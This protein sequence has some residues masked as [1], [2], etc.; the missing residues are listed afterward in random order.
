MEDPV[1]N[2]EQEKLIKDS[3]H[4]SASDSTFNLDIECRQFSVGWQFDSRAFEH[5]SLLGCPFWSYHSFMLVQR[6]YPVSYHFKKNYRTCIAFYFHLMR[7]IPF[8]CRFRLGNNG[9]N[10]CLRNWIHFACCSVLSENR[11]EE[12]SYNNIC[13][14]IYSSCVHSHIRYC[15]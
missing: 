7:Y 11:R 5:W 3:V 8:R 14:C 6:P 10:S 1:K 2:S 15:M 12:G 9:L 4:S 13:W